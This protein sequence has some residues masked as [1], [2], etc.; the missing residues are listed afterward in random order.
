MPKKRPPPEITQ[1]DVGELEKVT[2]GLKKG[3]VIK[4]DE[5]KDNY[6]IIKESLFI[7][8]LKD[9]GLLC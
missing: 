3:K 1:Q 5:P 9:R 2:T 8:K 6:L 4:Y 7:L